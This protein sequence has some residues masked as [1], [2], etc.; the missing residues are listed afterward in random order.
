MKM[1][2]LLKIASDGVDIVIIAV[3]DDYS[4]VDV[5]S[6]VCEECDWDYSGKVYIDEEISVPVSFVDLD[7]PFVG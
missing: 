4:A 1:A 2:K 5:I 7:R 6:R 3:E